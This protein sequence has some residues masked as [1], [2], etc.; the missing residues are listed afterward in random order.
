MLNAQH[1]LFQILD[2]AKKMVVFARQYRRL[3]G[4]FFSSPVSVFLLFL[5][6]LYVFNIRG[7][8]LGTETENKKRDQLTESDDFRDIVLADVGSLEYYEN[9][10][11]KLTPIELD[12]DEFLMEYAL[13]CAVVEVN[14]NETLPVCPCVPEVLCK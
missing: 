14:E 5:V 11:K 2:F 10:M 12:K 6:I 9:A 8:L 3:V 13:N 7:R 4:R 1:A